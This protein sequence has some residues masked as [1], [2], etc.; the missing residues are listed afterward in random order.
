MN[1]D[2]MPDFSLKIGT[3][4]S[5]EGRCGSMDTFLWNRSENG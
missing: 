5:G 4:Y 3:D 2:D 1:E